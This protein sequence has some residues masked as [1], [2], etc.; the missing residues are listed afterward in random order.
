MRRL[1]ALGLALL[2]ALLLGL[3]GTAHGIPVLAHHKT[4]HEQGPGSEDPD[5]AAGPVLEASGTRVGPRETVRLT[6]TAEA[7]ITGGTWQ[8]RDGDGEWRDLASWADEGSGSTRVTR[9]VRS[10]PEPGVRW[11]KVRVTTAAGASV[12]NRVAVRTLSADP[13]RSPDTTDGFKAVTWNVYYGTPVAELRPILARLLRDGV[14]IFLMQEM[15]NPDARRMLEEQGLAY[16]YVGYQWVVAWNPEVWSGS[17]LR[18]VR[19]SDTSF[20]RYDGTGPVY[21]DS[22]LATLENGVGRTVQVMSYHLPPNVQVRNPERNRLRIDRQAA[23]T[24]RRLVDTST[25]DA[26]LFGGDDNVDEKHGYRADG[27]FFDFLRRPATGLRQVQAPTGTIGPGR[28]IDD[29]RVRG[30]APGR[31]YTGDGGG[32]HKFFVSAFSWR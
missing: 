27:P 12:S 3:P 4:G 10:L 17:G 19:L 22:A 13:I 20:T 32:D 14:S 9:D 31:A 30:L 26:V 8:A 23:A 29:F 5:E 24:W 6:V 1:L 16:H 7:P 18:G 25:T 28:R 2:A 21:V 15:S 11:F